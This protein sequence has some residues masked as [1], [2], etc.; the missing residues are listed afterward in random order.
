MLYNILIKIVYAFTRVI[1]NLKY[2]GFE[3]IP[4]EGGVIICPNHKSFW[5]PV[6]V[7]VLLKRHP[8]F[9]AK[10]ELFKFPPFAWVLRKFNAHPIKR[11]AADLT[12]IKTFVRTLKDGNLVMIFPE[13]TR[14]RKGK[15]SKGHNG[16][17]RIAL[18]SDAQIVP[19]G[20]KGNFRWFRP[21]KVSAGVPFDLSAYRGRRATEEEVT[22]IT[23]EIMREIYTLAGE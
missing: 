6:V 12:A 10:E 14:V 1:F 9:M 13:G 4:A 15:E 2:E 21:V 16:A 3:N 11:G 19:V 7:T 18:M 5:D 8:V 22:G 17:V 20:I 23:N